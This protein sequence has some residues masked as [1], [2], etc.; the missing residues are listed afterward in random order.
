M[1]IDGRKLD[2]ATQAHLR[3]QVVLA[4]RSG[5]TQVQ[6]ARVYGLSLRAVV[7]VCDH[8]AAQ[9][10]FS[11]CSGFEILLSGLEREEE[12]ER[13]WPLAHLDTAQSALLLIAMMR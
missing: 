12:S 8:L 5:M 6:A 11:R 2:R 9:P 1:K 3:R 13:N 4:V 7:T 10:R